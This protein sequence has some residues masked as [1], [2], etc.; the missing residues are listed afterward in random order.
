[1]YLLFYNG[2]VVDHNEQTDGTPAATDNS[3]DAKPLKSARLFFR[4][5]EY[6][7]SGR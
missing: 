6:I 3:V 7:L 5:A 2:S 1:M 4:D